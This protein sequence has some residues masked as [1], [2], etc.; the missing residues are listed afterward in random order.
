M[1][2]SLEEIKLHLKYSPL[3]TIALAVLITTLS[4]L[5]PENA[6]EKYGLAL[7]VA[8]VQ[9]WRF[10]TNH[11]V[12]AGATHFTMNLLGLVFLGGILENAGVKRKHMLQGIL[13]AMVFSDLFVLISQAI[14]PSI[15][16][17]FSGT[18]YGFISMM[19]SIVGWR[20]VLVF[21]IL[22]FGFGALTRGPNIAWSG[23]I[24]GFVGGLLVGEKHR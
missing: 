15:V 11:F 10:V 20:G 13:M 16:V 21:A 24:G 23:H 1:G 5:Q 12:H 18:I 22:F 8:F 4:F 17:G 14:E 7:Q 3:L 2:E 6:V 19:V 9:P